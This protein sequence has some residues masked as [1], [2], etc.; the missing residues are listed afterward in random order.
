MQAAVLNGPGKFEIVQQEKPVP[1]ANQ[2]L[3]KVDICGICTSEIDMWLGKNPSLEYPLFIGHEVAGTIAEIGA[4]VTELNVGDPV[5]VW[6]DGKGYAEYLVSDPVFAYKL[7]PDTVLIQALGEPIACS[8]NGV[9]KLS[10]KFNDN[11]AIVGCGF[12]GLIML[13]LFKIRGVG[14]VIAID[15]REDILKLAHDLG[16]DHIINPT[17]N[18]VVTFVKELTGGK[19]VDIGVE[20]GG[21]QAT[22]DLTT[23]LVRMEG[24]LEVF[25]YHQGS[26]RKVDWGFWNWMAFQIVNGHTRSPEIYIEGMK[27]G[28]E[29][30]ERKKLNMAQLVTHNVPISEINDGFKLASEKPVGFVKSVVTF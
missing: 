1:N 4:E 15:L 3:V 27:I 9:R 2:I 22:L 14:D 11:V 29:L 8:V 20:A 16:A 18:D 10:P 30:L 21:S 5:A 19:G 17:N 7:M 12:M 23:Q 6:S 25:G 26:H 13:Q 24:K 28:L